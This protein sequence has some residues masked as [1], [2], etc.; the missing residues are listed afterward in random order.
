MNEGGV[1]RRRPYSLSTD[2]TNH[3]NRRDQAAKID[4][5]CPVE[6]CAPSAR[7]LNRLIAPFVRSV[8]S[9]SGR[10]PLGR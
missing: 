5:P 9:F 8:D 1:S 3:T 7:D 2:H 10:R 6:S 4:E